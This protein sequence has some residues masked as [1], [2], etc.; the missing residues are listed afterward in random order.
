MVWD[1]KRNARRVGAL[2]I[3]V[4]FL[5]KL[6]YSIIN[7][8]SRQG[9]LGSLATYEPKNGGIHGRNKTSSK[10]TSSSVI[11]NSSKPDDELWVLL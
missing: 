1:G 9:F 3:Q 10:I 11:A 4:S 2:L 7:E 8:F 6:F 5:A